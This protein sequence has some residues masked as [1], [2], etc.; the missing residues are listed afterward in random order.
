MSVRKRAFQN[1]ETNNYD[2]FLYKIPQFINFHRKLEFGK[3]SILKF[4]N[5]IINIIRQNPNKTHVLA[6]MLIMTVQTKHRN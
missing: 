3:N 6:L 2:I 4:T 5:E 1:G